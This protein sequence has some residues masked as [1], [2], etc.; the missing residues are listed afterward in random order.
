M[1]AREI[2]KQLP[3]SIFLVWSTG[4]QI[5]NDFLHTGLEISL[6]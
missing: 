5:Q 3:L 4:V 2:Y 6:L 1:Y